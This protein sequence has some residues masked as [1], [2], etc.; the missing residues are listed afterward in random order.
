MRRQPKGRRRRRGRRHVQIGQ[1][2][3]LRGIGAG[4]GA[5]GQ[6]LAF[7][8]A[9]RGMYLPGG[10]L[11]HTRQQPQLLG[12]VVDEDGGGEK[13]G[14]TILLHFQGYYYSTY[15]RHGWRGNLTLG[16]GR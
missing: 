6:R 15:K 14:E 7:E 4:Q 8:A 1:D 5:R 16:W 13:H 2:H 9:K 12:A 10:A 3:G 11:E